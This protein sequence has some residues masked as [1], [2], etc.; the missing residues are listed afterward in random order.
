MT[1]RCRTELPTALGISS[2]V[3][4]APESAV[5]SVSEVVVAL[6]ADPL[7]WEDPPFEP[8]QLV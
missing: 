3:N 5:H 7:S 8:P 2:W 6:P 4:M 1:S